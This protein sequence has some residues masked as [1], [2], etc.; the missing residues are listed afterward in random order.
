MKKII[1]KYANIKKSIIFVK[2]KS[3]DE[4]KLYLFL[5]RKLKYMLYDMLFNLES[6]KKRF[7]F[8]KLS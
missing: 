3:K 8:A 6:N 7:I 5:E 2:S 1:L 4:E